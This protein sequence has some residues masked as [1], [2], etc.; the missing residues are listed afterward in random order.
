MSTKRVLPNLPIN[1]KRP[2]AYGVIAR[3]LASITFLKLA[4]MK[5]TQRV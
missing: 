3:F 2:S 5:E 4:T 1:P